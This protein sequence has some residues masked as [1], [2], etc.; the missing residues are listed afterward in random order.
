MTDGEGQEKG[1]WKMKERRWE[2][3]E[4][5]RRNRRKG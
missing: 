4:S 2:M 5:G 1:R 3:E